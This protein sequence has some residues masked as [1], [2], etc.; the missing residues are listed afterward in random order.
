MALEGA[1]YRLTASVFVVANV[2]NL[3]TPLMERLDE[4]RY[5][6]CRRFQALHW[7]N[8]RICQ[9]SLCVSIRK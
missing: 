6:F 2:L 1:N 5:S 4:L 7:H 3:S 9:P 8:R